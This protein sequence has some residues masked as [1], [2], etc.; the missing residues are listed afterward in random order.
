MKGLTTFSP[1]SQA[2]LLLVPLYLRDGRISIGAGKKYEFILKVVFCKRKAFFDHV[3]TLPEEIQHAG[4]S[5]THF[6]MFPLM[7]VYLDAGVTEDG[8]ATLGDG[9]P[10]F[11]YFGKH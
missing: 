7:C 2:K 9:S 3:L 6:S 5:S 1:A 11:R 4:I 10:S 8:Y